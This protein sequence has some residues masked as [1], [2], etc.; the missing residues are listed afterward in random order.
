MTS[1]KQTKNARRRMTEPTIRETLEL[2]PRDRLVNQGQ[3]RLESQ[4]QSEQLVRA[5]LAAFVCDGEFEVGMHRILDRFLAHQGGPLIENAWVSGFYGSGKSHLLKMLAHLWENTRFEDG[6]TARGLVEARLPE[7]LRAAFRE[8]DTRAQRAGTKTVAAADT[9]LSGDGRV[10]TNVLEV[11]LRSRGL[12]TDISEARFSF[13]LQDEGIHDAVRS[14][15]EEKGRDWTRELRALTVSRELAGAVLESAPDL[16]AGPAEALQ[17][18]KD[19][20]GRVSGDIST[21]EF[22]DLA[23]RALGD[24]DALPLTMLILDEAQQYI[25]KK[26]RRAA[27]FTE[28]AEALQ[29]RFDGRLALVASGQSSLQGTPELQKLR[30]RFRIQVELTDADVEVVTR[31]VLLGK[32]QTHLPEIEA[33]FAAS[34]GEVSRHLKDAR[35]GS[36]T[37]DRETRTDDYPL[38]APRR[39]FWE[40]CLRAVDRGGGNAQLRSQLR[41][42]HDSL[43]AIADQPLGVVIPASDLF[44]QMVGLFLASGELLNEVHTRIQRLGQ[45]TGDGLGRD[46]AALAFLIAKLPRQAAVDAGVRADAATFA[47]LLVADITADSAP[48]RKRVEETLESLTNAGELMRVGDEYR[49]QT[50]EGAE[51]DQDF[52]RNEAQL[53][54]DASRIGGERGRLFRELV[55]GFVSKLRLLHGAANV[56]RHAGLHAEPGPPNDPDRERQVMV[57]LRDGWECSPKDCEAAA[58]SA[59]SDDPVVHVHIPKERADELEG[60]IVEALA[61]RRVL[62]VRGTPA[63]GSGRDARRSLQSRL[64]RAE[65]DRGT[66]LSALLR[67]ARVFV[68][69]GDEITGNDLAARI[70]SAVERGLAR[71]YPRFSE[72]DHSL[73]RQALDRAR[74]NGDKPF[75]PVDWDRDPVDHP[76]AKEVLSQIGTKSTPGSQIQRKLAMPPFG[77]PQDAVDAALLSLHAAEHLRARRNGE[78]VLPGKLTQAQIKTTEFEPEHIVLTVKQKI[79]LR[80]LFGKTGVEVPGGKESEGAGRYLDA[81]RALAERVGGE[82]PLPT[83]PVSALLDEASGSAGNAQLEL[84]HENHEEFEKL[85][86]HWQE[87]ADRRDARE[88]AWQLTVA[89]HR[90]AEG[91]DPQEEVGEELA[92]V[93]K[94]RSLLEPADPLAGITPRLAQALREEVTKLHGELAT[95]IENALRELRSDPRWSALDASEQERLSQVHR[96]IPPAALDLGTDEA[97]RRALDGRSLDAWRAEV[98]AT[99]ARLT[100]ALGDLPQLAEDDASAPTPVA[101]PRR[102]LRDEAAVREWLEDTGKRLLEAVRKGPVQPE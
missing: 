42:L 64:D 100:R 44:H 50:A 82:A 7:D 60:R 65:A 47:D 6:S 63:S 67:S 30:D 36:R 88:K 39:R 96:L 28:A 14:R 68:G 38:L 66:I 22:V 86:Q 2:D 80:G 75:E 93:R 84:I 35:I 95:T 21:D 70:Q 40:A 23:R 46:L 29:T 52:R 26:D 90:Y 48:F 58:R 31:K 43:G 73:W 34:E 49:I 51:W 8:L 87:R 56:K 27:D 92:A 99:A 18:F 83:K 25:G 33:M 101:L 76:V 81:L 71:L 62:E 13:W 24:G 94:N 3:A 19:R 77:W 53:G 1:G 57:W 15:V 79:A 72:G 78:P 41:I 69:G 9:L 4:G 20:F 32:K 85:R 97:L 98:D 11:V 102:T 91:L 16:A 89:F 55:E 54:N 17:L 74:Q 10:R 59:G 45:Q 61:A 37:A 12:P 5:E